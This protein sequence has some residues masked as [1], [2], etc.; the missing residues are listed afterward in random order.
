MKII[1]EIAKN[2]W[3]NILRNNTVAILGVV[4]ISIL[5]LSAYVGFEN[6]EK[7]DTIRH[8]YQTIV[9][10]QWMAQPNRHPHR[11]AHYGYLVFREKAPLSFFDFGI[12]SFVGNT[13]FLEAHRQNT[14]NLS[15]AGFS[16]GLLR[17]GELSMAMVLQLL[18]PLFIFFIGFGT[19]ANLKEN[20]VLSIIL[21]QGVSLKTLLWGKIL[22][23][24][25]FIITLFL[26]TIVVGFSVVFYIQEVHISSDTFYRTVILLLVY[27]FYF[28]ICTW[29]TVMVSAYAQKAGNAL[30]I[31]ILLW[32]ACGIIMP[33]MAQTI[34]TGIYPAISK[35]QF[36]ENIAQD[37]SKEGDSHNPD[38]PH[39][40]AFKTTLLKKYGVDSVQS[41]PFNYGGYVMAE[42]E[43]ITAKLFNKHFD[44]LID[45]YQNQNRIADWLSFINPYLLIRAISMAVSGTDM[46][47]YIAFQRQ[48][49]AYRY[50]QTQWLN[51]LHTHKIAAKSDKV[52]RVNNTLFKQYKTFQYQPTTLYW[53]F[54][55]QLI[56]LIS[57]IFWILVLGNSVSLMAK[58]MTIL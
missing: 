11:V 53:A 54:S 26:S 33:K 47:H 23:I 58:K 45:T 10:N 57:G 12:E 6:R 15:E 34:G 9:K 32:M 38:D 52:Q 40:V 42:G 41:L 29:A 14:V 31:L 16:N 51:D 20:G 43:R 56:L 5:W 55:N 4:F 18:S 39:Y 21:S 44:A 22:G 3:L 35:L 28:G 19:V 27:S 1:R 30:I 37:L 8:T 24:Y 25:S 7:Q 13:V 49:E 2:E 48:A 46:A 50:Q 17:F 36:E